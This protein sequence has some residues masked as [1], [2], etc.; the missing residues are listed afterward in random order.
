MRTISVKLPEPLATWLDRA[1]S[2]RSRSRSEII[3]EALERWQA[4]ARAGDGP[5]V[6]E[7]LGDLRGSVSGPRD[8]STNPKHL[9]GY[10]A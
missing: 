3:R 10:G 4:A 2:E 9:R 7:A 5:S 8:L 1:A 6:A